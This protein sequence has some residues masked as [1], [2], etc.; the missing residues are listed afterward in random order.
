MSSQGA[1]V[2]HVDFKP[3]A[4]G[5]QRL[6]Q[7]L[8]KLNSKLFD[9]A[10]KKAVNKVVSAEPVLIDIKQAKDVIPGMVKER[11]LHAGPPISW[12][13]MCG[14]MKGA[15]LGALVYEGLAKNL[16]EAE[17]VASSGDIEF[18]PTHDYNCVGP[19]AGII[20]ASMYVF[21]VKNEVDGNYAYATLNEGLGRVLRFGANSPDVI[22]R[23]K[24]M[25]KV[26]APALA[27]AVRNS[28]GINLKNIISQAIMMGDEC[29]NRN[30]AATT[31]FLK[32]IVPHLLNTRIPGNTVKE[33]I[34]FISNNPQFFLNLSMASCKVSCDTIVGFKNST[35]VSCIAR[36]GVKI[37]IRIAGLGKKWFT[38]DAGMP[39]GLY[40]PGFS[41]KD[42]NPDLGD[43]TIT[44]TAGIGANAMAAAPAIVKFVGGTPQDAMNYTTE[45]YEITVAKHP[46][47]C[48]PI[49]NFAGTPVGFDLRKIVET[50]ITPV[51]NTG[52][53]H[54]KPGIGQ[55]GAGI[56]RAPIECFEQALLEFE[57]QKL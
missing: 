45:M 57:N 12:E 54:K 10:N 48:I 20:S 19:M 16:R 27:E 17:I 34:E 36:N 1:D 21:V 50:G 3:P 6:I 51:I 56:L 42:A 55:V 53:A 28:N 11:M 31:L 46:H 14:P 2:V 9:E 23:L 29:H 40:F 4:G 15:I 24:W 52:I 22:E 35:V 33:V 7:I 5:N 43:S 37:G 41:E 44:E 32:E 25:E 39:K 26:L 30:I 47:F 8:T 49:L 18:V 38:A 13:E